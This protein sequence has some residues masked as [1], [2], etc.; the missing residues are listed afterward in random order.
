ML[1]IS[2]CLSVVQHEFSTFQSIYVQPSTH[3][4]T[5]NSTPS[6]DVLFIKYYLQ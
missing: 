4:Q 1:S 6:G 3:C 2:K 5:D